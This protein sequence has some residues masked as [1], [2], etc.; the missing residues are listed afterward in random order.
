MF[1]RKKRVNREV[2]FCKIES[3]QEAFGYNDIEMSELLGLTCY[4]DKDGKNK[5]STQFYNYR[6]YGMVPMPAYLG[7]VN[8]LRVAIESEARDKRK[9]LDDIVGIDY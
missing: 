1:N 9:M 2:E 5:G 6:K 8:A 3:I 4:I 7:V